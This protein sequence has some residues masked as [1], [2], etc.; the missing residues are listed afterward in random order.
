[1]L[2]AAGQGSRF[3]GIKQL[4]CV[5]GKT[6]INSTL[7]KYFI[8]TKLLQGINKLT[9]ILGAHAEKIR[10][11]LPSQVD[12]SIATD[13]Q[14]GMG[15]SIGFAVSQISRD[16]THIMIALGDQIAI[17]TQDV[18]LLLA[19]SADLPDKIIAASYLEKIGAPAI[20]PRRYF[21]ELECLV[22]DKGARVLLQRHRENV[23]Q[24]PMPRAAIDIDTGDDLVAWLRGKA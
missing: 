14:Q 22:G 12:V 4:A 7:D 24:M 17:E 23:V 13:W 6:L 18:R 20:F 21:P 16:V 8:D 2:L 3:N 5:A 11:V 10:P 1:M 15:R 9:V 19:Q